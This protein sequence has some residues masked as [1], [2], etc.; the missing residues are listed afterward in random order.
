MLSSAGAAGAGLLLVLLVSGHS[1]VLAHAPGKCLRIPVVAVPPTINGVIDPAESWGAPILTVNLG[2]ANCA[3]PTQRVYAVRT[4]GAGGRTYV[5]V[6]VPES[7]ENNAGD[8]VVVF[9][10]GNHAA[11]AALDASDRAV[12]LVG[13]PVGSN[14][15]PSPVA[16][17][18]TGAAAGWG[19]PASFS[20]VKYSRTGSGIAA[21]LVVEM[22]LPLSAP[23]MGFALMV[24]SGDDRD[25]QGD[26]VR[27][28]LFS[29]DSPQ[30]SFSATPP[31]N[32][33]PN[34]W[35]DLREVCSPMVD[36][37]P[38]TCCYSNDISF[39][40]NGALRPQPFTTAAPVTDIT[41]TVHNL[42][43]SL[44]ATNVKVEIRV[45]GFGMGSP[46]FLAA[47][48]IPSLSPSTSLPTSSATWATPI[49]GHG[50]FRA[51]IQPPASATD[52]TI[53]P[54]SAAQ[55]NVDVGSLS[56]GEKKNLKFTIFNPDE[57]KELKVLLTK[58]ERIPQGMKGLTFQLIQPDRPLRPREEFEATLAVAAPTG[59]ATTNT[60]TQKA[61]VP[62]TAGGSVRGPVEDRAAEAGGTGAL[63]PVRIAVKPGDRLHVMGRGEVDIDGAGPVGSAGPGGRDVSKEFPEERFLLA[64][65]AARR[66][67]GAL[68]GS[69]D[70]FAT[71]FVLGQE[72][73]LTVPEKV[74]ALWLAVND[75]VGRHADNAGQ[76]F[77]VETW[78]L[79]A[80][81]KPDAAVAEVD[82][83]AT[84]TDEVKVGPHTYKLGKALAGVTYQ[85]LVT[86]APG[87][88]PTPPT[89]DRWKLWLLLLLLAIV[90]VILVLRKKKP[91]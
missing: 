14:L 76:G 16:E 20:T 24:L 81:G 6:D 89:R 48:S 44:T 25:C 33:T 27:D 86:A 82:V 79:P 57:T 55:Y 9:L 63:D 4:E 59:M 5:A 60:P 69:F 87:T 65:D 84:T 78:T 13:F 42:D 53:G 64:G 54:N 83:F 41:A 32:S 47:P 39:R 51:V 17:I 71:S 90:V 18:Y 56:P 28:N 68:I 21:R 34:E 3:L 80:A 70:G 45:H 26:F 88:G 77:D 91:V 73:T 37:S 72:A 29:P 12:R 61:H 66:A 1:P 31:H 35:G 46:L 23:A 15:T 40:Q 38:P 30:P 11:G 22:E 49:S 19:P 50:C 75:V 85:V 58:R 67:G 2:G 36:F 10:R 43:T 62:P 8:M 52:Y 7:A 74:D